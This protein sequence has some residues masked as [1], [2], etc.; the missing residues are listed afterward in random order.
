MSISLRQS[1]AQRS[2]IIGHRSNRQIR[3]AA[4]KISA[5]DKNRGQV[6]LFFKAIRQNLKIKTYL[7]TTSDEVKAQLWA[8]L[9]VMPIPRYPLQFLAFGRSL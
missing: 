6:A 3:F 8:A 2:D 4:T 1:T 5:I 7:D 9:S